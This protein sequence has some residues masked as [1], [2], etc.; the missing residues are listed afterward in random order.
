MAYTDREDLNYLG[1]LYLVGAYQT[2]F[3]N[4]IGGINQGK[5]TNSFLFP[6]AQPW[7]LTAASQ[8]AITE[9]ASVAG[10]TLD[11][12]TRGNDT[13]TVQ[14]FQRGFGVSYAKQS[15]FGE[16]GA[17]ANHYG[18]NPG[19]PVKDELSFQKMAKLKQIALDMDYTFLQ[20]SYQAAVDATTAGKTRGLANAIST[21]TVAAG[22]VKLTKDMINQLLKEMADNGAQW[23]DMMLVCNSFNK[24]VITSLYE[25][26][27]EHRNIGGSNIQ[28]IETDFC[29]MGV[30][31]DPNM[32]TSSIFIVDMSVIS[33]VFCPVK[34]EVII[35]EPLAKTAAMESWQMYMQAGL[36]YGPEEFHGSVT[37]TAVA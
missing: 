33:P 9:A 30:M 16:I 35:V 37:G 29:K 21:N 10:V 8:P 7:A 12:N 28:Q 26:A 31:Y 6:V 4:A 13:N 15:T 23:G 24:Q 17:I 20:G 3:L 32:P 27:P 36:D 19:N 2:P 1:M 11:T 25:Y 18:S 34:G 14:I 5:T 22:G